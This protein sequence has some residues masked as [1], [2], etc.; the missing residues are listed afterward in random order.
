MPNAKTN[1]TPKQTYY[2]DEGLYINSVGECY[3]LVPTL[4]KFQPPRDLYNPLY[5]PTPETAKLMLELV[6]H[7]VPEHFNVELITHPHV[8]G[9]PTYGIRVQ[10]GS[11]ELEVD[12]GLVAN[13]YARFDA[14][15]AAQ[16]VLADLKQAGFKL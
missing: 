1:T 5:F 13:I 3:R 4:A 7:N 12:A 14:D 15:R 9:Y 16:S 6:R 2:I 10:S 8:A 11:T